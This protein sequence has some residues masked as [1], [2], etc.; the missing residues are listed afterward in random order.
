[1]IINIALGI[2]AFIS[3][4]YFIS[5]FI[6]MAENDKKGIYTG[7][8]YC[9]MKCIVFGMITYTFIGKLLGG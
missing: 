2:F 3:F 7:A 9:L 5:S 1:M 6:E 4:C 8:M